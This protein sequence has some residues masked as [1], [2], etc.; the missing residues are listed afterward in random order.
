MNQETKYI[1][2]ILE[3]ILFILAEIRDRLPIKENSYAVE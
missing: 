1:Y 2:E 3:R